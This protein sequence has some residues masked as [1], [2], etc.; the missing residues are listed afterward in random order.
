MTEQRIFGWLLFCIEA[1]VLGYMSGQWGMPL[2]AIAFTGCGIFFGLRLPL[3]RRWISAI[4]LVLALVLLLNGATA[5]SLPQEL[6]SPVI[7]VT[8]VMT[9]ARVLLMVQS[10]EF[11]RKQEDDILPISQIGLG[12]MVLVCAGTLEAPPDANTIYLASVVIYV[13]MGAVYLDLCLKRGRRIDPSHRFR[14]ALPNAVLLV[15]A[16]ALAQV[17]LYGMDH[18]RP[19]VEQ[20]WSRLLLAAASPRVP[21]I[22]FP[23][24]PTLDSIAGLKTEHPERIALRVYSR[25]SPTYLR[26]KVYGRFRGG[27]W[28]ERDF[29]SRRSWGDERYEK[30]LGPMPFV[31][32]NLPNPRIDESVFELRTVRPKQYTAYDVCPDSNRSG[33]IFIP[34]GTSH[35][36]LRSNFVSVNEYGIITDTSSEGV[37]YD[38]RCYVPLQGQPEPITD[39]MEELLLRRIQARPPEHVRRSTYAKNAEPPAE[40]VQKIASEI[41]VDRN[42]VREKCLAVERY[43]NEHYQYSLRIQVPQGHDPLDYFLRDRPAAHCEY[44][45]S[46]AVALLRQGDVPARYV[47]GYVTSEWNPFGKYWLSRDK[48][49]HAWAEAYDPQRGWIVV[50]ATPSEG[51]PSGQ[52]STYLGRLNDFFV[53]LNAM[54]RHPNPEVRMQVWLGLLQSP[55]GWV[56]AVVGFAWFVWILFRLVRIGLRHVEAWRHEPVDPVVHTLH[57]LLKRMDW[58]VSR[59]GFSRLP[60]ETLN[61]FADR[62]SSVSGLEPIAAWYH[63]YAAA[64]YAKQFD[65]TVLTE[66]NRS[67]QPAAVAVESTNGTGEE[68]AA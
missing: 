26:G 23:D 25:R 40:L 36:Q 32:E 58:R 17:S 20:I 13:V 5:P 45:A 56:A 48:D 21:R 15:L 4:T 33:G 49:A 47:T 61:Q 41:F 31:P 24:H 42:T 67:P 50:E 68:S 66:L 12:S 52:G 54:L 22:S 51:V 53:N 18:L 6:D 62:L 35:I 27:Q 65:A 39:E 14:R 19:H 28:Y 3:S 46:A 2:G 7:P 9:L 38:Y 10:I 63:K 16:A 29:G 57:L 37:S 43:F 34:P 55:V 30:P 60:G 59:M 11:C 1:L 64:R 8:I 44:F